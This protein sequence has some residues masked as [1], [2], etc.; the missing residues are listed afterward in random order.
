MFYWNKVQF[1]SLWIKLIV[2]PLCNPFFRKRKNL[3]LFLQIKS[4]FLR[5][6]F[7]K[8]ALTLKSEI[9]A[10]F[11]NFVK[12]FSSTEQ[13]S[14]CRTCYSLS[15]L[16]C[17][18]RVIYMFFEIFLFFLLIFLKIKIFIQKV[19]CKSDFFTP[20]SAGKPG[21]VLKW[22]GALDLQPNRAKFL[23]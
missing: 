20:L 9:L 13:I 17:V 2:T 12:M 10:N 21:L 14:C 15:I 4:R 6:L 16:R 8:A 1:E 19:S 22:K 23:T 3:L 5:F 18:N 7:G 11:S